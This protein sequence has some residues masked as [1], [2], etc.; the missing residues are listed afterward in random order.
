MPKSHPQATIRTPVKRM[1][2]EGS[3]MSSP[4]VID[5]ATAVCP[6]CG[7]ERPHYTSNR[8]GPGLMAEHDRASRAM[9]EDAPPS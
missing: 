2:C 7:A 9:K 3:H 1:R 5:A 4:R 8:A 6:S